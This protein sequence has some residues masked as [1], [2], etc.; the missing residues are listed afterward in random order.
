M[1]NLSTNNR[2]AYQG[3][4]IATLARFRSEAKYIYEHW[5]VDVATNDY[6]A[7]LFR[8]Q[9]NTPISSN[10][11]ATLKKLADWFL[12]AVKPLW[13]LYWKFH[14]RGKIYDVQGDRKSRNGLVLLM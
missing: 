8:A 14:K 1:A 5:G 4:A 3:D 7:S 2:C 11:L 9:P 6:P 13:L 10:H 12:R